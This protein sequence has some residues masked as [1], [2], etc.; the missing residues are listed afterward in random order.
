MIAEDKKLGMDLKILFWLMNGK[1]SNLPSHVS[2]YF[3]V[4]WRNVSY[5]VWVGSFQP[6]ILSEKGTDSHVD[7]GQGNS[8][9]HKFQQLSLYTK[10]LWS[11]LVNQNEHN[12]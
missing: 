7:S 6:N 5:Q 10:Y 3:V 8:S 2:D 4:K 1:Q 9:W 12:I 11:H